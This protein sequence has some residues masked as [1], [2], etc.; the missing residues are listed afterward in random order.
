MNRGINPS[1]KVIH[2]AVKATGEFLG[3]KIAGAAAEKPICWRNNYKIR[4][5][6]RSVKRIKTS[7]MKI[8]HYEISKLLND[9]SVSKLVRKKWM[10]ANDYQAA[11]NLSIKILGLKL[12]C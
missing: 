5:K 1:K 11:N 4:K 8:E 2:K 6:R 3:N 12:Q 10:E 7:I 9:S